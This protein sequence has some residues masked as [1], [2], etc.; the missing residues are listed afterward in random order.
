M[1]DRGVATVSIRIITG[2][3]R[4]VLKTLPSESVHAVVTSP[5][6]WGLRDYGTAKWD[7]GDPACEHMA[8]NGQRT[9]WAN[10]RPGPAGAEGKNAYSRNE[11]K[12][13]GGVCGKCG[14]RRIDSQIGL[15]STYQE[16]VEQMVAVFREVRRVLRSDG[17]CFLNLGDSYQDKQLLGMP[18]RVAFAL[19]EPFYTGNIKREADRA[20]LAA[21]VD[22]EGCIGIRRQSSSGNRNSEWNDSFIPYLAIK[23]SDRAPLDKAVAITGFGS[24][25]TEDFRVG[26]DG[27]GVKTRRMPYLWRLD[28]NKAVQV[29]REIYPYLLVK[30]PQAALIYT[31]DLSNKEKRRGRGNVVPADE[32][33]LREKI[34]CMIKG[35]NQRQIGELPDWCE[36]P[37]SM[38]E[39]GWYLR[40]DII[41]SKKNPMPE[42]VTDRCTKSHEYVFLLSKSARYYYDAEAIK[43]SVATTTLKDRREFYSNKP[44]F[45]GNPRIKGEIGHP[46]P[47]D[48]SGRNRRSVWEIATAPFSEV[49]FATFP[50]ALIEPCILAG[51]SAK[52]CCAKCGA[53]WARKTEAKYSAP[54]SR[55][56]STDIDRTRYA[57]QKM[58]GVGYRPDS[59]LL[60]NTT[61]LGWSPSCACNANV[62]PCTVL[63]PFGG[64]GTTGLVADRLQ[65]DAVLIELNP[66]YADMARKRIVGDAPLFVA[67]E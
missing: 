44:G 49:H 8:V 37:A 12:E 7:G 26:E 4:D 59:V 25:R 53:P 21:L 65:R 51:T 36:V 34:F 56:R 43:E 55:G 41:W 9:P 66:S 5:P 27:R 46:L 16:F 11:T 28:G 35:F 58:T 17:V 39:Q 19:Q 2:D 57:G 47:T 62:V 29:A 30:A 1:L 15:E 63:D 67:A 3:C 32:I 48:L 14:A 40:Q 23:M 54:T 64:A 60:K 42:S 38:V 13:T 22:G 10:S 45:S 31:L 18:W 20:W 61:T 52:G 33:A 24:V 6:Y 50:P